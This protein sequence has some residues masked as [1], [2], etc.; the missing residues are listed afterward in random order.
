MIGILASRIVDLSGKPALVIAHEA[1]EAYGSG[2]SV[3]GFHLL[4][5]L[6]HC[7]SLFT[8][9]GGHAHAVG[10]SLPSTR[11]PALRAAIEAY[12]AE[13]LADEALGR[14]LACDA[15]LPLNR[16]TPTLFRQLRLLE[17]T[18]MGNEEPV[19]IARGVRISAE[20][21]YMKEH[22][23]R[24]QLTQGMATYSALGWRWGER[25]RAMDLIPGDELAVAYKLREN[26]HPEYG[27][28]ELEIVDLEPLR[29]R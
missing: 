21:R 28:L 6:E 25:I 17:P 14:S 11:V 8:R 13:R 5:A 1:D 16:I 19:L 18:G 15:E 26:E 23:A 22:H 3:E 10:F 29:E 12:A 2:R 27:G 7:G 9:Y 4:E 24:L 20:P